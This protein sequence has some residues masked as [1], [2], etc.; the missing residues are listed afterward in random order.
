MNIK[1][2]GTNNYIN[3]YNNNKVCQVKKQEKVTVSDRIEISS[4]GKSLKNY[5]MDGVNVDNSK[6]ISE[7]KAQIEAGTYNANAKLTA[8]GMLDV[9]KGRK[10]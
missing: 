10:L 9:M 3:A 5:S 2:I 1:G 6:K 4:M 7:L 8:K